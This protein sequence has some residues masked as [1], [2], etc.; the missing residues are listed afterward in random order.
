MINDFILKV[1]LR[2]LLPSSILDK[3]SEA[4]RYNTLVDF[5]KRALKSSAI[6]VKGPEKFLRLFLFVLILF[7]K[8]LQFMTFKIVTVDSGLNKVSIIHPILDD[9]MRLY[10]LL[11]M[12][13]AFEDDTF[14]VENGFLATKDLAKSLKI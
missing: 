9:G 4:S 3:F 10:I 7:L 14:R 12:F 8:L 13:A 5:I 2:G 1:V 11:A 6:Y